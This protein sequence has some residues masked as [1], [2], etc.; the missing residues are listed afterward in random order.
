MGAYCISIDV[1]KEKK[2]IIPKKRDRFKERD[3]VDINTKLIYKIL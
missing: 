1:A 2:R 3:G